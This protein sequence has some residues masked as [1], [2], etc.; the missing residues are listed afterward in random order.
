VLL[1]AVSGAG[2]RAGKTSCAVTLL[3]ALPA[4]SALAVKF[5]TTEDVFERC[6][7]HAPC[8]VCDI[9]VP[10]RVVTDEAVL[11][12]A[13][14]DTDRLGRAGAGRVLWVITRRHALEAAWGAVR[15]AMRAFDTAVLEG[16]TIVERAQPDVEVFVVHP[17]LSPSRWKD[18]TPRRVREA[19]LV[20]INRPRAEGRPPAPDVVAEL[21]RHRGGRGFVVAD[22]TE[23]L[24]AWAPG[25][26]AAERRVSA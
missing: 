18:T 16:S 12:E 9:D 13:G 20:V 24:A 10:F 26:L 1:I 19:D 15:E 17:F 6:P 11:R 8:V 3:E 2:S 5:T 23:P 14:T 21:E 22:V 4:G 7:R 25:L